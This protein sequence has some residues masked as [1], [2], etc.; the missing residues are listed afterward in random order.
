MTSGGY[1]MR[2]ARAMQTF[3]GRLTCRR[4]ANFDGKTVPRCQPV[5]AACLEKWLEMECRALAGKDK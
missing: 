3:T 1:T 5:C 4:S 2:E